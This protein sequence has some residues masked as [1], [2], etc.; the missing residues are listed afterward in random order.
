MQMVSRNGLKTE[1]TFVEIGP[2][3]EE[4]SLYRKHN[5]LGGPPCSLILRFGAVR[6]LIEIPSS[7][8]FQPQVQRLKLGTMDFEVVSKS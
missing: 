6:A 2:R 8:C 4:T 5:T 3:Q 1:T 7:R